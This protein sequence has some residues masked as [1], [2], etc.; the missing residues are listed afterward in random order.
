MPSGIH[1]DADFRCMQEIAV[2]Y[3]QNLWSAKTL[4]V[5]FGA[6]VTWLHP[7]RSG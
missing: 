5:V 6:N 7:D 1:E 4:S 3:D 2:Y